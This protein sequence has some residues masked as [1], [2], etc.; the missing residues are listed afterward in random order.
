MAT[1]CLTNRLQHYVVLTDRE[2][3]FIAQMEKDERSLTRRTPI[4]TAGQASGD[5]ML[6]KYG[7]AVVRGASLR[8]RRPIL[9]IYLAGEIIGLAEI[10]RK[11]VLHSIY[12]QTDGAICPFPRNMVP[13]LYRTV[14]RLAALLTALESSDHLRTREQLQVATRATAAEK[15][16]YLLLS[17]HNRLSLAGG[18]E[19]KRFRLPFS[20]AELGDVV[21]LTPV[22]I[23]RILQDL[24]EGHL[25]D[26]ADHHVSIPDVEQLRSQLSFTPMSTEMDT[27]WFPPPDTA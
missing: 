5:L 8:N 25:I 6:L 10:S 12:M 23:N 21:G 9:R 2:A 26:Y 11:E 22:Y 3:E 27:D 4:C 18:V 19:S 20:Q 15:I 24:R 13:E 16:A 17:L 14:P 1:S 7:W